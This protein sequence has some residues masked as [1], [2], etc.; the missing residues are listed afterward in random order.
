MLFRSAI[1]LASALSLAD[2]APGPSP[3][4]DAAA[5]AATTVP[6]STI[7]FSPVA[8][9]VASNLPACKCTPG[10]SCWPSTQIWSHFNATVSGALIK[11]TPIVISCYPGPQQNAAQCQNADNNWSDPYFQ[12]SQ[13]LGLSYPTNITCLPINATAGQTPGTCTLGTNPV[14]AVNAVNNNQV[15][16]AVLFAELFNIRLVIKTTGHDILGRSDGYGSLELWLHNYNNGA[17]FQSKYTSSSG[18]T[19]STWTGA[20]IVLNGP[21]HQ[22]HDVNPVAAANN[23]VVVGGG[24]PS[25]SSMG[26]WMQGGGHG[27]A[28]H[29]YGLGADQVLEAEIVLWNGTVITASVCKNT[30]IFF[31]TRGGG[32]SSYGVV[33]STTIKA[34]PNPESVQVQHLAIGALTANTSSLFDAVTAIFNGMP[35]AMDA[36]YTG[37]GTWSIASP[38]PL[39]ATFTAGYVHG[40]YMF[41]ATQQQAQAAWAPLRA[42]LAQYNST[43]FVSETYVSYS[44]YW[45]FY[46]VESGVEPSAGVT[47]ALGSRLFDRAAVNNTAG[48]RDMIGVIAGAPTEFTSNSV[49]FV[50]GGQVFRDAS[51]PNS[52]VLPACRKSYFNNIVARGWAP[53][54]P[55][56]TI[57]ATYHDITYNKVAAMKAQAPDT[58]AYMNEADRMDPDYQTD[59]YGS[60]Y[61]KLL[62]IKQRYDPLGVFYCPTCVGSSAFKPDSTGRLCRTS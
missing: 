26:G 47:S 33:V 15:A 23:V 50:S 24:T 61:A 9:M 54:S 51:D 19:K 30:D 10:D 20:A 38:T 35:D 46:N 49:E 56:A 11:T 16:A 12:A 52:G 21:G 39:F 4:T 58:G 40:I 44:D 7:D 5:A 25:V 59:F 2:A 45:S 27:P 8:T 18:C 42:K 55:Q 60:N 1:F 41:N 31:A 13:P 22:W 29:S 53:G 43:L 32:P 57:D 34:W 48:L 17:L 6:C 3:D 36:G 62:S 37:Y 28:T 14:Y